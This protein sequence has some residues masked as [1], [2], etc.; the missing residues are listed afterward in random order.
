MVR[1]RLSAALREGD[2]NLI[3]AAVSDWLSGLLIDEELVDVQAL[4]DETEDRR[5]ST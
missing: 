1:D 3:N 2:R 4:R 5:A